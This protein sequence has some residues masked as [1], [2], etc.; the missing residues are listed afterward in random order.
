[1]MSFFKIIFASYYDEDVRPRSVFEQL[2]LELW[3]AAVI[4]TIYTPL[5]IHY[6][7]VSKQDGNLIFFGIQEFLKAF[8]FA[9]IFTGHYIRVN[10]ALRTDHNFK[11]A[12]NK[13][14]NVSKQL[15]E[16]SNKLEERTN[17]ILGH[18]TGGDSFC[19]YSIEEVKGDEV[20]LEP[21]LKGN[22]A[23]TNI[24]CSISKGLFET[25]EIVNITQLNEF[26]GFNS[27]HVREV[28]WKEDKEADIIIGFFHLHKEWL[29]LLTL[30]KKDNKIMVGTVVQSGL[31]DETPL[32][33]DEYV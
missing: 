8:F 33:T 21:S 16:Q 6:S 11:K 12:E 27:R 20:I 4:A 25:S 2:A 10:K 9:G 3:I 24:T 22:Y 29:Q 5:S 18:L 14:L 7:Y 30:V 15:E 13:M 17:Q 23:L 26:N 28:V 32:H 19:Y 31:F 1:M